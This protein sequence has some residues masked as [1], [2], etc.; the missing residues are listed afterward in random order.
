MNIM[1]IFNKEN[2]IISTILSIIILVNLNSSTLIGADNVWVFPDT[3]DFNYDSNSNT[4]DALTISDD[5]GNVINVP[6]WIHGGPVNNF[7]YI[8]NQT[9]R[10][11]KVNFDSNCNNMHL[12]INLTDVSGNGPGSLCNLF[13]SNYSP[14]DWITITLDGTT[15]NSIGKHTLSLQWEIYAIP[16]DL[17][18][19]CP[20]LTNCVTGHAYYTLLDT[21]IAP[22]DKPWTRVLDYASNW[23]SGQSSEANIVKEITEGAYN[24]LGKNYNGKYD[25]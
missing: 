22:M 2:L 24:N 13:V 16:I 3:I 11:I 4:Y 17:A 19:Y 14:G 12:I 6:E 9:N 5:G 18:N 21:P 25:I 7:A 20:T 23:A 15:P 1:K 8:V 10:K